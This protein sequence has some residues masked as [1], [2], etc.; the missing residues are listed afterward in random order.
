MRLFASCLDTPLDRLL[1]PVLQIDNEPVANLGAGKILVTLYGQ[2]LPLDS[3]ILMEYLAPDGGYLW[4]D[5]A[6]LRPAPRYS[7]IL[8]PVFLAHVRKA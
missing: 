2:S 5:L 8:F 6:K 3:E 4:V 7:I 1:Q